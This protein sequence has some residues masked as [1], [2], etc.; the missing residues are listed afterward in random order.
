MGL[1]MLRI[2]VKYFGKVKTATNKLYEEIV[3]DGKTIK[4]LLLY[5]SKLYGK[6]FYDI[7]FK[8][9]K[10]AYDI[11]ILVN[12]KSIRDNIMKQL[13][14]GDTISILPFVSGG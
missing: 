2:K 14:D 10:L 3:F 13:H 11:I 7:I 5:L 4:G 8:N 9:N 12:G 6:R 1:K